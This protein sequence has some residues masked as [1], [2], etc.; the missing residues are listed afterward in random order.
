MF[1]GLSDESFDEQSKEH[2]VD[3]VIHV[4]SI[5]G[6]TQRPIAK[7]WWWWWLCKVGVHA[8]KSVLPLELLLPPPA[9]LPTLSISRWH[10]FWH[11]DSGTSTQ[12]KYVRTLSYDFG[13]TVRV[14][15]SNNVSRRNTGPKYFL[16]MYCKDQNSIETSSP[17]FQ[18]FSGK[19]LPVNRVGVSRVRPL[20]CNH[21]SKF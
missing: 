19:Y 10:T 8:H 9:P 4:I 2:S 18:R 3:H 12:T 20:R 5:H 1:W 13:F 14:R 11:R 6:P 15:D 17:F 21:W 7:C 16:H